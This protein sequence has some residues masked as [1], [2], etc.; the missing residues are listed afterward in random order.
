M[1][2]AEKVLSIVSVRGKK[3]LPIERIYRMLFN[4][5]FYLIAYQ[6]IY[7]NDGAMT[8]GVNRETVD[9]MSLKKIDD[10]IDKLKTE[11]YRWK[12]VKRVHIPKKNGKLRPLGLPTWSDKLL[13]E[14]IRLILEA[15]YEPQF[16][17]KSH[18]FRKSRGCQPALEA[19]K[20]KDGW[21][22][23]KWFVEGDISDCFGS[24]D[25]EILIRIMEK[26]IVDNRFLRLIK[27]LLKSG[28]IDDWKY[29]STISGCPQGGILSPLLSN[30]YMDILD[31][32]V[33]QHLMPKYTFGTKRAENKEYVQLKN[34]IRKFQRQENWVKIK[35][36]RNRIQKMPSKDPNDQNF[37][38]LYYI[39]YADDWLVG[40]SGNKSD[41]ETIKEEIKQFLISTLKLNLS[42]EKTLITHARNE[43]ARF[44]GYDIHV[45]HEDTKRD[46]RGQRIINGVIGLS[47]PD[48]K[49]RNKMKDY[50]A[51][52]KP[53]Q[54]KERTINSDY[55]IISQFQAEFRGFAQ[56]Y[57]LAYNAHKLS[58]LKRTLEL[59][60]AYTL[61]N[62]HKTT[63]NKV[64]KK[65]GA[66]RKTKDGE[67]KVL[68]VKVIREGKKPLEAYFGGIKLGYKKY[69]AIEDIPVINTIYSK[70]SQLV[71]RLLKNSC[72]LCGAKENIEMHHVRKLKDLERDDRK[73]K[74]EWMK[75]M[76]GIRRKTLAV[77]KTCHIKIHTGNYNGK[78]ITD[79]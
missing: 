43:K 33:E 2:S 71:D 65:Y 8:E 50:K 51:K 61:A 75:R 74:P 72:E 22:S 3:K 19:I 36:F 18:G 13:Q 38:R 26:K 42:A 5:E 69:S 62:K 66:Y 76:I 57:L 46:K 60:L 14:V 20:S 53:K 24:I 11:S 48:E 79:N 55:D 9:S 15:Y 73:E 59:S 77:C 68:Q 4:K 7:S 44:L 39:R 16:S 78:K 41:A 1:Q 23:V 28:Y 10:I 47:I 58:G 25:H 32:F 12:P 29:N 30:I 64:F 34:Q 27:N 52:G 56:Y 45:L 40:V 31:K 6:N 49:I 70:R 63:V 54:R 67:Y 17:D 35:E 21:K 37:K